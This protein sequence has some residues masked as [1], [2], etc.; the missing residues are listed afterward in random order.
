MAPSNASGQSPLRIG[1]L[2]VDPALDEVGK[3]GRTIKLE[4]KAMQLLVCLAERPGKVFSVEELLD[5]VWK[6]VV[7]SIDSVYAA[8]AALRRV[9]GDDPK[10]P[11]YIANV[12][13]RGYRLIAPVAPWTEEPAAVEPASAT[14]PP[15]RLSIAVLPLVNLG[16]DPAQEYFSDGL[17]EDIITELARW[18]LLAVRSR[19]ASFRF[20]GASADIEQV[21]R[22]LNVRYVVEGSVRRIGDTIRIHVQLINARSGA[23]VWAEKFDRNAGEIFAIQ[24][25][26]VQTI[27]STL[28]GRVQ[29]VDT[30]R[31][32]RKPPGSLEAYECVLKGNALPWDDPAG[33]AEATRLFQRA[34]ELDPGYGFA[35]ALLSSM[36]VVAWKEQFGESPALLDEAYRLAQ[37]SVQLADNE[38]TC[39]SLLAQAHLVRREFDLALQRMHRALELNPNNQWNL[40]DMAYVLGYLGEGEQAFQWS[41]RAMQADPYFGPKWFLRQQARSRL[42]MQMYED[43]LGLLERIPKGWW[44]DAAYMAGCHARLGMAQRARVCAAECL[45]MRPDFTIRGLLRIEPFKSDAH[46]DSVAQSLRLAGLPD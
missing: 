11:T 22:E 2:R 46:A 29:V 37:R 16:G 44:M 17:T 10:N 32:R 39:H 30:E 45:A 9:L 34:I 31:A 28:V 43:A 36:H 19:S 8:V 40:A 25:M 4:R 18:P 14:G 33:A 13:R 35:Y 7:V 42:I 3:S 21:A 24:D 41:A 12:A 26:V 27:V 6:D 38:S 15:E 20:R 1:D 23:H 5:L